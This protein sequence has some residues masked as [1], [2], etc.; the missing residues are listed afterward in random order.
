MQ[1]F[2]ALLLLCMYIN[3]YMILYYIF[4]TCILLLHRHL[5]NFYFY[6]Y[7]SF[8]ENYIYLA[9]VWNSV[10]IW[11]ASVRY[12]ALD[13]MQKGTV[14]L[15]KQGY[16]CEMRQYLPLEHARHTDS[17]VNYWKWIIQIRDWRLTSRKSCR[18]SEVGWARV[19]V[20]QNQC[21]FVSWC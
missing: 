4:K 17:V 16:L 12:S 6:C 5:N 18:G 7:E 10:I 9:Y 11:L 14:S 20:A 3:S 21:E 8:N 1:L 19:V 13:H 15:Y 2:I